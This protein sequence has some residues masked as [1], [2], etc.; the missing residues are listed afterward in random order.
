MK[1]NIIKSNII[2]LF[3]TILIMFFNLYEML[4]TFYNLDGLNTAFLISLFF[5]AYD[6]D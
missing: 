6:N 4:K 1:K 2:L 5:T 3:Y